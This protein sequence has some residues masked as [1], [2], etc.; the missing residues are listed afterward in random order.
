MTKMRLILIAIIPL[1][2]LSCTNESE[3]ADQISVDLN[4]SMTA[5][6][7]TMEWT[8]GPNTSASVNFLTEQIHIEGFN[9]DDGIVR[10]H[11]TL[12]VDA[13]SV[14]TFD[15][16]SAKG[17]YY[18]VQSKKTYISENNCNVDITELNIKDAFISGK[19]SFN[20]IDLN[21][22]EVRE[23]MSGEFSKIN[24]STQE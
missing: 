13:T 19:F 12:I 2:I 21:S 8:S 1:L 7:N 20:G 4:G 22:G 16:Q 10:S 14:G 17:V 5:I 15:F 23:V 11:I 6:M 9:A 3:N 24:L 18:D